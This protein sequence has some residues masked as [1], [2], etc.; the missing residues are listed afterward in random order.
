MIAAFLSCS[1]L[2]SGDLVSWV[3]TLNNVQK[4]KYHQILKNGNSTRLKNTLQSRRS[5]SDSLRWSRASSTFSLLGDKIRPY[6]VYQSWF[7]ALHIN[8]DKTVAR[9][10]SHFNAIILWIRFK[11]YTWH[12]EWLR[13]KILEPC[14]LGIDLF[15]FL[16]TT[17]YFIDGEKGAFW[18][19]FKSWSSNSLRRKEF[20]NKLQSN[21]WWRCFGKEAKFSFG[22]GWKVNQ[23]S[24]ETWTSHSP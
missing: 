8:R 9:W 6:Q 3:W 5:R 21:N 22:Q 15:V 13:P 7:A 2:K 23:T 19:Q 12:T 16:Q 17:S 18:K 10:Q 20:V 4:K 11:W 24:L 1:C 14:K